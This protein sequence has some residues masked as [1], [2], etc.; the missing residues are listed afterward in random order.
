VLKSLRAIGF[1]QYYQAEQRGWVLYL[2]GS[3]D[4]AILKAF[5]ALLEHP[6]EGLLEQ[7]FVHY[8]ANQ[9]SKARDH[10]FGLKEAKPDLVGIAIFDLISADL[11]LS[12]P[13]YELQ[14]SQREIENYL[15]YPETLLAYAE[16][17]EEDPGPLFESQ[18][19]DQQLE[20]MRASIEEVSAA[21]K[22]IR[23][24]EPFGPLVKASDDFLAPVFE[25]YFGKL[26]L[27]NLMQKTDYHTLVHFVPEQLVDPEIEGKLDRIV[28]VAALAKP[29][30]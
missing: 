28:E 3:T 19:R 11:G 10:F 15:C 12:G 13:L 20:A 18:L 30:P 26:R 6:A 1:E 4:L 9:V 23:R 29:S 5:A 22:L 27:P 2:E 14:W 17:I 25:S 16:R 8:V 7:P 21:L 24:V